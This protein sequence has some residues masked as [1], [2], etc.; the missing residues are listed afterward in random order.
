[1]TNNY[2]VLKGYNFSDSYAL[3]VAHLADRLKGVGEF[4]AIWPRDTKFP[5]LEQRKA[6]QAAL[7]RLELLRRSRRWPAWPDDLGG[8]R[9]IP[10]QPRR[11]CRRLHDARRF[12]RTHGREIAATGC[13]HFDRKPRHT[14]PMLR[15]SILLLLIVLFVA[16]DVAPVM[17]QGLFGGFGQ[18]QQQDPNAPQKPKRKTL[19]D[20]LFGGG[21]QQRPDAASGACRW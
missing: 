6:I 4:T 3:A 18:Q 14:L 20:M 8:V 9:Q 12:Q 7:I 16:V 10:G 13:L 5:D 19:F 17:A 11:G 2:L 21:D 1:M 15:R